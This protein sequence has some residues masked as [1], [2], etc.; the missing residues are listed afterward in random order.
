MLKFIN[1]L[2]NYGVVLLLGVV[3]LMAGS[4]TGCTDVSWVWWVLKH[5]TAVPSYYLASISAAPAYYTEALKCCTTK[6]PEYYTTAHVAP[7]Y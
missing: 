1:C 6:A 2:V 5:K 3:S 7:S 4:T